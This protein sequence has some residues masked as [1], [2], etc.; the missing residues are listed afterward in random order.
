MDHM[1]GLGGVNIKLFAS[2]NSSLKMS[3]MIV[4]IGEIIANWFMIDIDRWMTR[5]N[6]KWRGIVK[7]NVRIN[8]NVSKLFR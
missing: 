3:C 8:K 1:R 2:L 7:P 6:M 5:D 4:I